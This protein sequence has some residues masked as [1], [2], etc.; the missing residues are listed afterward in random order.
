MKANPKA[1]KFTLGLQIEHH[2]SY[3]TEYVTA[4]VCRQEDDKDYPV[5]ISG[6]G[7]A[8]WDNSVPT[9]LRDKALD[10]LGMHGF[11]SEYSDCEYIAF[12]PEF[13]STYSCN[14]RKLKRMLNGLRLVKRQIEKDQAR[15]PEATF[16]ALGDALKIKFVVERVTPKGYQQ[17]AT[18]RWMEV[19]EGRNRF[20]QL[21][22]NART[23]QRERKGLAV[24]S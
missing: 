11:V 3:G 18:W 14:E 21:I 4:L 19:S 20:R 15:T 24:A 10:G 12:E 5:G 1:E 7:W 2:L 6:D 13:R 16:R 23:A 8:S 17:V 22:E 9:Y